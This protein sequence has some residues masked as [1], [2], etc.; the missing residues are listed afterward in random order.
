[1]SANKVILSEVM[2]PLQANA[3]GNINGGEIMK[4]METAAYT[5]AKRYAGTNVVTACVD[6]LD[7]IRPILVGD[8]IM[9]KAEIVYTGRTSI[10]VMVEMN[11]Q[12]LEAELVTKAYF[13]MVALDENHK[14]TSVP[15]L[16]P[17][18]EAD[19]AAYEAGKQYYES[20]KARR[21]K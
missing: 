12:A 2:M 15:A 21:K 6:E 20:I 11:V 4:I 16:T 7:F 19:K 13:T 8:D 1:M 17:Q 14:P 5:A 9:C 18:S 10:I 3:S